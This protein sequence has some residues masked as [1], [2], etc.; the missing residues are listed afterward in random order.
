MIDVIPNWNK[1]KFKPKQNQLFNW[2][3]FLQQ[4][5]ISL[6]GGKPYDSLQL[7]SFR[8]QQWKLS[9]WI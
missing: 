9:F 5:K 3:I 1:Q 4:D 6:L 2:D 7:I 8:Q